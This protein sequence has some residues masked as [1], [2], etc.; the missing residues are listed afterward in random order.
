[1]R[2]TFFFLLL[3]SFISCNK[4]PIFERNYLGKAEALKNGELWEGRIIGSPTENATFFF[5]IISFNDAGFDER[6]LSFYN[7]PIEITSVELT[8]S[9]PDTL[10]TLPATRFITQTNDG[11][12]VGDRF[13]L[14]R[15]WPENH[16][17][18]TKVKNERKIEGNFQLAFE[19]DDRLGP[20]KDFS[21]PDTIIFKNGEF[22]LKLDE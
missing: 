9:H 20:R 6:T 5:A 14:I 18:I 3:I 4:E 11:H 19:F 8:I 12:G 15:D 21:E 2:Y 17:E 22:S 7:I 10:D 1:M 16:F 13:K